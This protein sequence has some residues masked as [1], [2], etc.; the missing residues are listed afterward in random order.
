VIHQVALLTGHEKITRR[1]WHAFKVSQ[2]QIVEEVV[3]CW[4]NIPPGSGDIQQRRPQASFD[5]DH[6]IG[7]FIAQSLCKLTEEV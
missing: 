4:E 2:G 3:Q 7:L 1:S 5:P 6:Q